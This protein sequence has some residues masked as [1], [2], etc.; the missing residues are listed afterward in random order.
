MKNEILIYMT[1]IPFKNKLQTFVFVF[2]FQAKERSNINQVFSNP[3][4]IKND[5]F[6]FQKNLVTLKLHH[7]VTY[8]HLCKKQQ[9]CLK[10]V[11]TIN[12]EAL[13]FKVI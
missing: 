10:V 13:G 5:Y 12:N 2:N 7:T 3:Y 6:I 4:V 11:I 8:I 9:I 1:S